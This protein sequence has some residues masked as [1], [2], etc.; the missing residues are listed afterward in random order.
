MDKSNVQLDELIVQLQNPLID[1]EKP[2]KEA[3]RVGKSFV[4]PQK[5]NVQAETLLLDSNK[6]EKKDRVDKSNVQANT[7]TQVLI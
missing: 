4:H 3:N 6:E 1:S 7:N 2:L 5:T